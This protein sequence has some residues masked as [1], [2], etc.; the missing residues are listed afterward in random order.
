METVKNEN[1]KRLTIF[2]LYNEQGASSRYRIYLFKEEFDKKFQTKIFPFWNGK[3]AKKYLKNKKKYTLNIA[4]LYVFC[5]IKRFFQII[6][7]AKKSDYV[8]FQK[9]VI[10]HLNFNFINYLKNRNVKVI[11]DV[12]D[13]IYLTDKGASNNIAKKVDK[14][15]VGNDNLKNYYRQFSDRIVV[16]PTIDYSHVYRMNWKDTFD[17][18]CIGWIG[19]KS[20][21]NN[22]DLIIEPINKLVKEHP[23]VTFNIICDNDYGYLEKIKN[24]KLIIWSENDYIYELSKLTVGIMPLKDNQFNRGKCGF[25]IIQYMCM[26]KPVCASDVGVNNYIVSN[27]GKLCNS[28]IEWYNSLNKLLFNH[29]EYKKCVHNIEN[30][31]EKKFNFEFI[32]KA[33]IENIED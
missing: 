29:E 32:A 17:A 4:I 19:S 26:K 9:A 27:G 20:T 12:D 33:Y 8:L 28:N 3:Y 11:F 31:F 16:I 25:K 7:I 1:G 15:I 10:P 14:I 6:F 30:E 18:K 21:I 5:T 23:E 2:T 13:A 24:S 22:L